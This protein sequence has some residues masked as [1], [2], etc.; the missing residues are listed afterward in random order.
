M[1]FERDARPFEY[2]N[3]PEKARAAEHPQQHP[4]WTTVGDICF[5]DGDGYLYLTDRKPS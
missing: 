4:D 3:D 5:L 2:H 1:Y